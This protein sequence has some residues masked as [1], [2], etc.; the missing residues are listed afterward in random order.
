MRSTR[1][2]ERDTITHDQKIEV[3]KTIEQYNNSLN[4]TH[5]QTHAGSM[6]NMADMS[7]G[8]FSKSEKALKP[9]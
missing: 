6:T 4:G 5:S 3:T 2:G 7:E 8:G 1:Y 9:W